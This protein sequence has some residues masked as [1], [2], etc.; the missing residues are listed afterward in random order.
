MVAAGVVDLDPKILLCLGVKVVD[1]SS[2]LLAD[3]H[4]VVDVISTLNDEV[5]LDG[6]NLLEDRLAVLYSVQFRFDVRVGEK[7]KFEGVATGAFGQ[8]VLGHRRERSSASYHG[9]KAPPIGLQHCSI[10]LG[11]F[12]SYRLLPS[13]VCRMRR[14]T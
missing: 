10:L 2:T 7:D 3:I 5:A 14:A 8:A 4:C 1:R 6:T 12:V 11:S 13:L 9:K